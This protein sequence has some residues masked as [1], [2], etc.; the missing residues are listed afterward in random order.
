MSQRVSTGV[1]SAH[2]RWVFA[3]SGGPARFN[4]YER[5]VPLQQ[6]ARVYR[7][8]L[9]WNALPGRAVMFGRELLER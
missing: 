7:D 9:A 6:D 8:D 1:L 3:H 4:S 5:Q 2:M